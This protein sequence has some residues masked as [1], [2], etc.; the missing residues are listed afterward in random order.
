[1]NRRAAIL[2]APTLALAAG[3]LRAQSWPARPVRFVVGFA[4]GG[5]NDIMARLLAAKL[6]E[7]IAGSSFVVENRPGASTVVGADLVARS[8]PDGTTFMFTSPSTLIAVLVN[9][10][11][12]IDPMQA[13][14]PVVMASSAPLAWDR[15]RAQAANSRATAGDERDI[16]RLQAHSGTD[17]LGRVASR[18]PRG[19]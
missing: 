2:A 5:A 12:T 3:P 6:T 10:I 19:P 15:T 18:R 4:P 1:M 14:V 8:A 13:L 17:G 7:R 9:R 11:T 16:R